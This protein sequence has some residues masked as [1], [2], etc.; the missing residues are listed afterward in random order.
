MN[1]IAVVLNHLKNVFRFLVH[2][3]AGCKRQ[4]KASPFVLALPGQWGPGIE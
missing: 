1:V 3:T 4:Q 2:D